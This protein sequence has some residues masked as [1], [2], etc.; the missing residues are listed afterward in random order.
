MGTF[1]QLLLG[2]VI[3]LVHTIILASLLLAWYT[4]IHHHCQ[5]LSVWLL[6]TLGDVI[7]RLPDHS[8]WHMICT[9]YVPLG[10]VHLTQ[11]H[12]IY[13]R[14]CLHKHA[15][16]NEQWAYSYKHSPAKDW[17]TYPWL[18]LWPPKAGY[19]GHKACVTY[20]PRKNTL[21]PKG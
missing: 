18:I 5:S 6:F 16:A 9:Q 2:M 1:C 20:S 19:S 13:I 14:P 7:G 10:I 8:W 17:E 15:I 3:Q 21:V 11:T 12:G 4:S